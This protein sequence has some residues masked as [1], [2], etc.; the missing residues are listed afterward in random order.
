MLSHC[1]KAPKWLK[2]HLI[3]VKSKYINPLIGDA[4]RL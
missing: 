2:F 1:A 3:E 4:F